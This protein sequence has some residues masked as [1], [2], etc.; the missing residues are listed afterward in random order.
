[1]YVDIG[2][3]DRVEEDGIESVCTERNGGKGYDMRI[4]Y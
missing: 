1:M 3:L 2:Y 4:Y